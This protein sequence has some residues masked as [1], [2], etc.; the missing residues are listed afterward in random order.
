MNDIPPIAGP[1][2]NQD[3]TEFFYTHSADIVSAEAVD[4]YI[5]RLAQAGVKTFVSCGNA[6]RANYASEVWESDWH[7]YDSDGP[8]DQPVL[9]HVLPE[10]VAP[11][12]RRIDSAKRLADLGV[13]FHER[14]LARCRHHGMGAWMTIRMNDVHGCMELD[15]PLLSTFYK[16]HRAAK[17]LRNTYRDTSWADRSLDWSRPDVHEH[18]FKLVC[19]QL[20]RYDMDGLELDWM[21][22]G[23]H[24]RPG[25]ELAGGRVITEWM[26]RVKAECERAAE[27][28]GH[29]VKLGVRVPSRPET[30]RMLGMDAVAWAKEGL[31]DV[32]APS[33]FW[34]TCEFDIPM[35]EWRRLLEGTSVELVGC[36]EI[37]YQPI[38]Y[39]PATMMTSELATG[40]A[41]SV[42]HGGADE[43]YLFN[44]FPSMHGLTDSWGA[45]TIDKV[46]QA[47]GDVSSL[48]ILPRRHAITYRDVRAP[49]EALD[50]ALPAT[51]LQNDM[52]SPSGCALRIKTGPKPVERV[53]EL[54]LEFDPKGAGADSLRVHVN[55]MK[56]PLIEVSADGVARFK[57]PCE[58]LVDESQVIDIIGGE[59]KAFTIVRAEMSI[60]GE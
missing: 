52:P 55:S 53:V 20:T 10:Q 59:A 58:H 17:L 26:R 41:L 25:H 13:D 49:G 34:A 32:V 33:P 2:F 23:Y 16:E 28:W 7:G 1:I 42:L 11:F 9:K 43:V 46:F 3:S 21:R 30:A 44:Y 14:A 40:A 4:A 36:L 39:G 27:R 54:L 47:M 5:D 12:R 48:E 22:F 51:D 37:R 57:V 45:E 35:Q 15:S 18:Y 38:P 31:V 56:C 60:A 24:F 8:D 6:Q 29:P 19:E 50:N